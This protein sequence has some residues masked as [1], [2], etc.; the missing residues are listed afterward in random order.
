M[1]DYTIRIYEDG[2]EADIAL[3]LEKV[4]QGWPGFDIDCNSID[5]WRWKYID[6]PSGNN[7]VVVVEDGE[8]LVGA[9]HSIENRIKIG[10]NIRRCHYVG[11]TVVHPEYRS[12]G[13]AGEMI[14]FC[15][16]WRRENNIDFSYF[17]TRHPHLISYNLRSPSADTF[18][19]KLA[20]LVWVEDVDL[21]LSKMPMQ[22]SWLM[23]T[24]LYG[25]RM[26]NRVKS[27]FRHRRRV[28]EDLDIIDLDILDD[29][30][31]ALWS[32]VAENHRYILV[33][34]RAYLNWRYIDPRA[35]GYHIKI[36][37]SSTRL[38][39]YIVLGI[40]KIRGNY[41]IGFIM[42]LLTREDSRDG[43][44][45]ALLSGALEYFK[46]QHVNLVNYLT[47]KGNPLTISFEDLGFVDSRVDV[48]LFLSILGDDKMLNI[49][50]ETPMTGLNVSYGDLDTM[51]TEIIPNRT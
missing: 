15:I 23:K 26:I 6:N 28:V 18:P 20:N 14:R 50:K 32:D 25:S 43:V 21:Q 40:N 48:H 31:D 46:D 16:K 5:H 29:R 22:R 36:A 10:D 39:G 41:P 34:D 38:E 33:K 4:F 17:V 12:R 30:L 24:G 37:E 35:G 44:T 13:I 42:D 9:M 3:L 27:L 8:Y 51:P 49:I 45:M 11:D 7:L 1:S 47:I 2:D 19:H